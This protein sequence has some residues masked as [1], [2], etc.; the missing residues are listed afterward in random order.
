MIEIRIGNLDEAQNVRF[1]K[2][3]LICTIEFVVLEIRIGNLD[4]AQNVRFQKIILICALNLYCSRYGL[5]TWMK[6]K[7]FVL[8][9]IRVG[10]LDEA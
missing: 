2:I 4:E 3:I 5:G 1:Q 6:L 9:E 10:N 7:I 8:L